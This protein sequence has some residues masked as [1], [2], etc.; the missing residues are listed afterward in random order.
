ML[1]AAGFAIFF[2]VIAEA[3]AQPPARTSYGSSPQD[4]IVP[5]ADGRPTPNWASALLSKPSLKYPHEAWRKGISGRGIC[6]LKIN[7]QTGTVTQATMTR[8]TGSS[9]LDAAT[10]SQF[11]RYR[12]KP[13]T[14]SNVTLPINWTFRPAARR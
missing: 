14:Y 11:R 10:V 12:F 1:A 8:S 9:I 7:R 2:F 6:H 4:L 3:P 13:G 5:L